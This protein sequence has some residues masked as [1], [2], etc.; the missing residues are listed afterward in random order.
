MSGIPIHKLTGSGNDFI[1][2]DG[3]RHAVADWPPERI[4]ALC[5][6]RT[7]VGADGL[8]VLEPGSAADAVRFHFFNS[9]G[10][11]AAMCGNAS[12]CATRVAVRLGL[13]PGPAMVLETDAGAFRT[14]C[15]AGPG[16]RAELFLP[17]VRGI[18]RPEIDRAAGE[19][20]IYL[21]TVGVPHLVVVVDDVRADPVNPRGRGR[22]LRFHPA[23]GPH[24][25]NVNFVSCREGAW[26]LRTYERGV[27]DETLACGTGAV[28]AA[29][30]LASQGRVRLPWS[31]RTASACQLEIWGSPTTD[32]SG[33]HDPGLRGE[34][35]LVFEG[36]IPGF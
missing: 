34:A 22:H 10:G 26:C 5:A 30:V 8:V 18:D 36:S 20:G 15:L 16:E 6:R 27:E 23:L 9:D 14:R 17:D 35:R 1:Y 12:L 4:R 28:A 32:P 31:V 7:G 25:A 29:A 2:I 21:V 24:G 11:R 13:V 33:I 19:R 3:R